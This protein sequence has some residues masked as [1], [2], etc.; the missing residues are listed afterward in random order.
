M[1]VANLTNDSSPHLLRRHY[2]SLVYPTARFLHA[3]AVPDHVVHSVFSSRWWLYSLDNI[4]SASS[5]A[6]TYLH[7]RLLPDDL[8]LPPAWRC[9]DGFH[10]LLLLRSHDAIF[11]E[12]HPCTSDLHCLQ[13]HAAFRPAWAVAI[14]TAPPASNHIEGWH[15]AFNSKGRERRPTHWAE[16]VDTGG[17]SPFWWRYAPGSGIFVHVGRSFVRPGKNAMLAGLIAEYCALHG[18]IGLDEV[19]VHMTNT[20]RVGKDLCFSLLPHLQLTANGSM[21]CTAAG[22]R[23]CIRSDLVLSDE[24][25]A[26]IIWLGRFLGFDTLLFT[27][28]L[29]RDSTCAQMA[30][31]VDL[32]TYPG[33]TGEHGA[34]GMVESLARAG[35]ISLRNPLNV[36]D[37]S[38]ARACNFSNDGPTLR[39]A[40][41]DH[42]SWAVRNEPRKQMSC[43]RSS[44]T[45]VLS[46]PPPATMSESPTPALLTSA[47]EHGHPHGHPHFIRHH[48]R[49][50]A[51]AV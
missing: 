1:V 45:P 40:C 4:S 51:G 35:R 8:I 23:P 21:T 28:S 43:T 6:T 22:L 29:S 12:L 50:G 31:F 25:D 42:V 14:E 24:W 41:K 32:R 47:R 27:A 49:R 38:A 48:A 2:L 3:H 7:L 39:L 19:L 17:P 15:L 44:P 11:P 10:R 16:F 18:H 5:A 20:A 13:R 46:S 26:D 30:E 37:D 34:E 33:R 9:D 36:G